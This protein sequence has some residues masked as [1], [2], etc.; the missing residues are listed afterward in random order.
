MPRIWNTTVGAR[1]PDEIN[2]DS[3]NALFPLEFSPTIRFTRFRLGT[4]R[5]LKHR[6]LVTFIC[7]IMNS[8]LSLSAW[9]VNY[10]YA[11]TGTSTVQRVERQGPDTRP[12]SCASLFKLY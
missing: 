3:R 7:S 1:E 8:S 11:V 9:C 2:T 6:K 10:I 4:S 12:R 5:C